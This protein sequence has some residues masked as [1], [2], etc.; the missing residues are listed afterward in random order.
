MT[1]VRI[2]VPATE[3]KFADLPFGEQL[4]IWAMRLWARTDTAK[5]QVHALLRKGFALAGIEDAHGAFDSLMTMLATT[6]TRPVDI[7]C[8]TCGTVSGDEQRLLG[9]LADHQNPGSGI[10]GDN[11][12][13]ES[14]LSVWLPPAARRLA[15]EPIG[16][17][18]R[19]LARMG[20]MIRLRR[21]ARGP[22]TAAGPAPRRTISPVTLH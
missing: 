2:P 14:F 9:A 19:T 17:L 21:Q 22:D 7:R 12:A 15:R 4:M 8:A 1:H 10:P 18:A 3:A 13:A 6:T 5:P 16:D 20:L 11:T